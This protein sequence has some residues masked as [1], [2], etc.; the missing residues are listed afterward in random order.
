MLAGGASLDGGWAVSMRFLAQ[1]LS[2]CVTPL[3]SDASNAEGPRKKRRVNDGSSAEDSVANVSAAEYG[4]LSRLVVIMLDTATEESYNNATHLEPII[5]KHS[6]LWEIPRDS[7]P[8]ISWA[9]EVVSAGYTRLLR[10]TTRYK[11]SE[12]VESS[13]STSSSSGN[14]DRNGER[15]YQ[16]VSAIVLCVH[17]QKL[18]NFSTVPGCIRI[19]RKDRHFRRR[20]RA[21]FGIHV[22]CICGAYRMVWARCRA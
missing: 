22:Q 5:A 18:N 4:I 1:R 11:S 3:A 10:S 6:V 16:Y 21:R 9:Q 15:L 19:C 2:E 17:Q 12:A 14:Q 8:E 7:Q 20:R 13:V